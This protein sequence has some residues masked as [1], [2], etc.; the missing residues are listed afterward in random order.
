MLPILWKIDGLILY[1]YPFM[2]GLAWGLAYMLAP[3][4]LRETK[5]QS[6][7]NT[8]FL[9][10]FI[11]SWLGAKLLF[12][13]TQNSSTTEQLVVQSN[14]WLGGGMVFYGG[15]IAGMICLLAYTVLVVKAP[16]TELLYLTPLIPLAHSVG[17][18]GCLMAGCCYGSPYHGFLHIHLHGV[19]RHPVQLYESLL[20]LIT[21]LILLSLYRKKVSSLTLFLTYTLL[22]PL[23]RLGLEFLRGDSIRGVYA[24]GLSTSQ[25]VSIAMMIG[26]IVLMAYY[27]L[28]ERKE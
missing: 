4:F 7:C 25:W 2:M 16:L 10:A 14:F 12:L 8:L 19:Y 11:S 1:S 6:R 27:R 5:L 22:Y 23:I 21:F 26:A 20:L 15:L 24:F 9:L 3:Y 13:M 28:Q 18:V 17:R